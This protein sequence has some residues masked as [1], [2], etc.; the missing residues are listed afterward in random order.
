L[1]HNKIDPFE[2][3]NLAENEEYSAMKNELK[4]EMMKVLNK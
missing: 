2:W 4:N 1:Y 3:N